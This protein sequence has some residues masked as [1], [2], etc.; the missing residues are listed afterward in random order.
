M[1]TKQSRYERSSALELFAKPPR[2]RLGCGLMNRLSLLAMLA[3][4]FFAGVQTQ[5]QEEQYVQIYNLI[6]AA[7][8]SA[9]SNQPL[10]TLNKYLRAQTDLQRFQKLYPDWNPR[11][12]N[13]R[14]N[15]LAAKSAELSGCLLYTSPSPR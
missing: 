15:Y 6:Q 7:D 9:S 8:A 5:A 2:I 14:L 11:I 4:L 3:V 12:V 13:F 1:K 10:Q